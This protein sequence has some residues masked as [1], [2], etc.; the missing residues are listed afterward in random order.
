LTNLG[1]KMNDAR[2]TLS[3]V[4]TVSLLTIA[5]LALGYIDYVTG[6]VSIDLIYFVFIGISTWRTGTWIGLVCVAE[7]VFVKLF[8]DYYDGFTINTNLYE[9]NSFSYAFIYTVT[10]VLIGKLKNIINK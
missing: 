4:I 6:D 9:W 3:V 2:S 1:R 7:V 5:A 10:C 8:A